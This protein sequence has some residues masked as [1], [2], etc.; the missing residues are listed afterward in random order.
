MIYNTFTIYVVMDNIYE[1]NLMQNKTNEVVEH[2][3]SKLNAKPSGR[4]SER[5]AGSHLLMLY[6]NMKGA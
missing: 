1:V 2:N 6:E 3:G 5:T 4:A